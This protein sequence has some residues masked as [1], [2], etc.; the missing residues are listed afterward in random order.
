MRTWMAFAKVLEVFGGSSSWS[1]ATRSS[2][3]SRLRP[4]HRR[5]A[6][7]RGRWSQ[8]ELTA[9]PTS[10]TGKGRYSHRRFVTG[11][12]RPDRLQTRLPNSLHAAA[13]DGLLLSSGATCAHLSNRV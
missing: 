8:R 6:R 3:I 11:Y 2:P 1:T 5:R 12:V 4:P 9:A 7:R 13:E 10:S